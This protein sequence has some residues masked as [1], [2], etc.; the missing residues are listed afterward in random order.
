MSLTGRAVISSWYSDRGTVDLSALLPAEMIPPNPSTGNRSWMAR[1]TGVRKWD[2]RGG[3]DYKMTRQGLRGIPPPT[4]ILA[5][6]QSL[7]SKVD[8]LQDNVKFLTEYKSAC[9]LAFTETWLKDQDQSE[10]DGFGVP[11]RVDRDPTVTVKSLGGGVC[12]YVNRSWSNMV[13]FRETLCTPH[14]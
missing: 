3:V 6:V 1:P 8:E 4:V 14:I 13:V 11:F 9:L 7:R 12:L 2:R 5:N 10:I